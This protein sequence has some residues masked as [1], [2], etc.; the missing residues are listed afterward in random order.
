MPTVNIALIRKVIE[1]N[2]H[3][4]GKQNMNTFFQLYYQHHS[5]DLGWHNKT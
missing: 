4:K 1:A 3:Y 5:R 2:C